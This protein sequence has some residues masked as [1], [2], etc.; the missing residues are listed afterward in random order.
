MLTFI[1]G[2]IDTCIFFTRHIKYHPIPILLDASP[3]LPNTFKIQHTTYE[4]SMWHGLDPL[5]K[6]PTL[7]FLQH[8]SPL[9]IFC[10]L[11]KCQYQCVIFSFPSKFISMYD[12]FL[13]FSCY[14]YVTLK[15]QSQLHIFLHPNKFT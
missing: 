8:E 9:F 7:R 5:S 14:I 10:S 13:I 3:I 4:V 2:S 12:F 11:P 6:H 1:L 15:L